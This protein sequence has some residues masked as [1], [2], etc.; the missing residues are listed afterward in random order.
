MKYLIKSLIIS[1]ILI[2]N[3]SY[4][5]DKTICLFLDNF[6]DVKLDSV[7]VL[8]KDKIYFSNNNGELF[9]D[10][11]KL[12]LTISVIDPRY[13]PKNIFIKNL[14]LIKIKLINKG[15]IL[16]DVTISSNLLSNK[17]KYATTSISV[18]DDIVFRKKENE[19][20]INSLN[21][22]TGLYS[23]SAGFNTNR[24]TIRGM[25]SRSPYSTNK[26]KAYKIGRAHV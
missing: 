4:S 20:V 21:Q 18:L 6:S 15:I 23:H 16:N 8:I 2:S 3:R 13:Y 9:I 14:E 12:P 7:Q 11:N 25:G 24:I 26:I 22:V 10:S 19:F 5:Q 17:L 1:L